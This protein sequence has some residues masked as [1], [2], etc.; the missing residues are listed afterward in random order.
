MIQVGYDG[1]SLH[2]IIVIDNEH[3]QIARL[4]FLKR[5]SPDHYAALLRAAYE[6][7][8][9]SIQEAKGNV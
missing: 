9:L 3:N 5:P 6:E 2:A 7:I 4:S 8:D 1:D